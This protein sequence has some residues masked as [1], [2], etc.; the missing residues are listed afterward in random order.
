MHAA[1]DSKFPNFKARCLRLA[2]R[3]WTT[4][5]VSQSAHAEQAGEREVHQGCSAL[6]NRSRS[7]AAVAAASLTSITTPAVVAPALIAAAAVATITTPAAVAAKLVLAGLLA[8]LPAENQ[9]SRWCAV[10]NAS[11][12]AGSGSAREPLSESGRG[13]THESR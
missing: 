3:C 13:E 5:S 10:Q 7:V 6:G 2:N 11:S 12:K 4:R 1:C 9:E 8:S